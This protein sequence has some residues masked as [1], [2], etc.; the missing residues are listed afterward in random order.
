MRIALIGYGKMGHAIE[1]L[2]SKRGH[3]IGLRIG[4]HNLEELTPENLRQCDVAIEFTR[5]EAAFGNVTRC[6][7][8]GV[9]VVCGTT[10]WRADLPRAIER[11]QQLGGA[12]LY[13]S[14]FS[15]GVNVVFAVN[16]RLAAL[17]C[18]FPEYRASIDETH[19]TEKRDAPSGTAVTL[20][21]GILQ[22]CDRYTG[23]QLTPLT[24]NQ[25]IPIT[26][27]RLPNVPGTHLVKWHSPIDTI[28]L[29]HTAHSR[30]GFAMG[31][32]LAAEWIRGK[33]G[34]FTMQDVLGV[35]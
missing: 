23:W 34:F 8:A 9:P 25:K 10:G 21:E 24:D 2:A 16:A 6:L 14:N 5:P 31:A 3:E 17:L 27:H 35:G 20:A 11:C 19:H 33:K 18:R 13:A 1:A 15:V 22:H 28:E 30:E 29:K 26:A 4:S 7:E 32:I 12:F